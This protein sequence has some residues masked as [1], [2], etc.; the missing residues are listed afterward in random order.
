MSKSFVM[1]FALNS[2]AT[3]TISLSGPKDD[4][5]AESAGACMNSLVTAG[6]A[7]VDPLKTALRGEVI[8]RNVT[9]LVNNER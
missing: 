9:V 6:G 3:R 8:D 4:L 1:K 7:F 5:N 2:G